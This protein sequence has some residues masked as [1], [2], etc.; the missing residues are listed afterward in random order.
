MPSPIKAI[1]DM[2]V[3]DAKRSVTVHITAADI[4]GADHKEPAKCAAARACMR[5]LKVMEARIHLGRIYLRTNNSNWQR[6]LT[7]RNMRTEIIAFD[8]GGT[9]EP[10][11]YTFQ[12]PNPTHRLGKKTGAKAKWRKPTGKIRKSPHIV[13]NVR[14]GPA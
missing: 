11:E 10:G 12:A 14:T 8:R 4:K 3:I 5:E 13:T 1:D 7:P 9:F 2:P 6:Y